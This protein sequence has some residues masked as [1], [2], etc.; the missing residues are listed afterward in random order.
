MREPTG[1]RLRQPAIRP[2]PS[3]RVQSSYEWL[4][5]AKP[6][7][8]DASLLIITSDDLTPAILPLVRHKNAI[9]TATIFASMTMIKRDLPGDDD[10]E[11]VKRL[12]V[13]AHQRMKIRYVMLAGDA[14]LGHVPVRHRCVEHL[15]TPGLD[16]RR[17]YVATDHYYA[18]LYRSHDKFQINSWDSE[19]APDGNFNTQVWGQSTWLQNTDQVEGFPD[20]VVGR[21]PAAN[22][23]Q[24]KLYVSKVILYET[25][26]VRSVKSYAF[27]GNRT[28]P[29]PTVPSPSCLMGEEIIKS[30]DG[31]DNKSIFRFGLNYAANETILSGW[32]KGNVGDLVAAAGN[33]AWI[34]YIG[35]GAPREWSD[36]IS[37]GDTYNLQNQDSFPV[38]MS[39]GCET[40]QFSPDLPWDVSGRSVLYHDMN[41]KQHSFQKPAIGVSI[42]I[43]SRDGS[44]H[45]TPLVMPR[46]QPYDVATPSS[47]RCMASAWLFASANNGKPSGAIAYL[48]ENIVLQP[49]L[50]NE[51][52]FEMLKASH[53]DGYQTIGDAWRKAQVA[54]F[55][56]H[57]AKPVYGD[58]NFEHPRCYLSTMGLFGDP[59]LR[60]ARST[61]W[62]QLPGA[63]AD[64]AVGANGSA[65]VV[66]TNRV[67]QNG[68]LGLFRLTGGNW[69]GIDGA[70]MRIAVDPD[71]APWI[72]NSAKKIF[73]RNQGKWVEMPGAAN[74]I[75][76]G[77]DGSVWVIGANSVGSGGDFGV[78]RWT[79]ST[80]AGIPGGGIRIAVD[81][82]GAPWIVNSGG[83]IFRWDNQMWHELPGAGKDV[84]IGADGTVWVIGTK[85]IGGAGDFGIHRWS[86]SKWVGYDGGG[87]AISAG[88]N[89]TPWVVN[90]ANNIFKLEE[91]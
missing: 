14:N 62:T 54:Y 56:K 88:Q 53:G 78:H 11:R 9:G 6:P 25:Q 82:L 35:H 86:G 73:W 61:Q 77:A 23:E 67:G 30:L 79:G 29:E 38:V 69:V 33:S 55:A 50:A 31:V 58:P 59:S 72:V 75:A 80:W 47:G 91:A 4:N 64:I 17:N 7:R 5:F 87:V 85:A 19:S 13:F 28:F 42:V 89:G 65:W 32:T 49:D 27:F 70:G 84:G 63:A 83:K 45:P 66:G 8:M 36:A 1:V 24:L 18:D 90:A 26:N 71:G 46:Q 37:M 10:A 34:S 40:G 15:I 81:R 3:E 43:D 60:L 76:I 41:N 16:L 44:S 51:F 52:Q 48:G 2:V 21:V 57:F 68:D 74:D 20:V 39:S 12:I 22:N